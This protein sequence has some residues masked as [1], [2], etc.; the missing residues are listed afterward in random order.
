M[1]LGRSQYR[2]IKGSGEILLGDKLVGLRDDGTETAREVRLPDACACTGMTYLLK[3][4]DGQAP[5]KVTLVP[6]KGQLVDGAA[7]HKLRAKRGV[8]EI[9]S[10]GCHWQLL[11]SGAP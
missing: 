8:C 4:E 9:Y 2:Q 3:D 5:G 10:D 7:I 1:P 6:R 11:R